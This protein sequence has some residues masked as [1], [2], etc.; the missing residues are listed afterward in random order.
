MLTHCH[1]FINHH[2]SSPVESLCYI[3]GYGR[4]IQTHPLLMGWL[5]EV[6]DLLLLLLFGVFSF[7]T[8][9][10]HGSVLQL[11]EEK[12]RRGGEG[13]EGGGDNYNVPMFVM[14]L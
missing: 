10:L 13:G 9:V 1:D 7:F 5:R 11:V 8:M 2:H 6:L 3:L 14:I 4:K 12:E